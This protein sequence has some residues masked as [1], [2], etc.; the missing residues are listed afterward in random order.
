MKLRVS[1]EAIKTAVAP[2]QFTPIDILS[3]MP[4]LQVGEFECCVLTLTC[5]QIAIVANEMIL[6]YAK[7]EN[8]LNGFDPISLV[9]DETIYYDQG[10][11]EI[12][13]KITPEGNPQV[14]NEEFSKVRELMFGAREAN[15]QLI[16]EPDLTEDTENNG[17][18]D[19]SEDTTNAS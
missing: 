15:A 11:R 8:F 19:S 16:D 17:L 1:C 10:A 13:F 9:K 12:D 2:Y 6:V 7:L 3:I 14:D 5:N 4:R 18:N